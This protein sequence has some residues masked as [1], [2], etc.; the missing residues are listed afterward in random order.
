MDSR[1]TKQYWE[2]QYDALTYCARVLRHISDQNP[3]SEQLKRLARAIEIKATL[4]G[5][6]KLGHNDDGKHE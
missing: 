5:H 1:A 4:M 3:T 6:N 2:G